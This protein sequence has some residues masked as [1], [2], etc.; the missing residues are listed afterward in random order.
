MVPH[1]PVFWLSDLGY[2]EN[3]LPALTSL[4]EGTGHEAVASAAM[5]RH[6]RDLYQ[7]VIL[8]EPGMDRFRLVRKSHSK[9]LPIIQNASSKLAC[10]FE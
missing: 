5:P 6:W 8:N 3:S 10:T 9:G 7:A 4:L 2:Y 1:P